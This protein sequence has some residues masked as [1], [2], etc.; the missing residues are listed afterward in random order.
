M[1]KSIGKLSLFSREAMVEDFSK[2]RDVVGKVNTSNNKFV[3]RQPCGWAGLVAL[4]D[5]VCVGKVLPQTA[6]TRIQI[7]FRLNPLMRFLIGIYL[8][9]LGIIFLADPNPKNWTSSSWMYLAWGVSIATVSRWGRQDKEQDLMNFLEETL[10]AK[11]VSL[12]SLTVR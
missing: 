6:G 10:K 11:E 7:Q 9:G 3:I 12:Q 8:A 2:I 5:P 4:S 1:T